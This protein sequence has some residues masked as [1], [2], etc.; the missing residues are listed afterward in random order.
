M[1]GN[2]FGGWKTRHFNLD[3]SGTLFYADANQSEILGSFSLQYAYAIPQLKKDAETDKPGFIVSEYKKAFFGSPLPEGKNN[4]GLPSG[5]I[6]V[7][8]VFYADTVQERDSW[9][10]CLLGV[11]CR[12]RP[13]DYIAQELFEKTTSSDKYTSISQDS[14]PSSRN[15]SVTNLA[16]PVSD[17]ITATKE[18]EQLQSSGSLQRLKTTSSEKLKPQESLGRPAGILASGPPSLPSEESGSN[19]PESDSSVTPNVSAPVQLP[20]EPLAA[21]ARES[22]TKMGAQR[23]RPVGMMS[24]A[25]LATFTQVNRPQSRNIDDQTRCLQQTLP[26]TLVE[27]LDLSPTKPSLDSKKKPAN[28]GKGMFKDWIKRGNSESQKPNGKPALAKP[29]FGTTIQEAVAMSAIKEGVPIPAIVY[30]CIEYLDSTKAA[31]EEGLYRLSGAS[32][33][34]SALKARFEEEGDVP[35][36]DTDQY[37]DPHAIAGLL[38]LFFRE[39]SEPLFTFQLRMNFFQQKITEVSKLIAS[40]PLPNYACL[41]A[42]LAHLLRVVQKSDVNKMTVRNI[43]IVFSPTLGVPAGLFTLF[44]AEFST[45]FAW[46]VTDKTRQSHGAGSSAVPILMSVTPETVEENKPPTREE[47]PPAVVTPQTAQSTIP[48]TADSS[49]NHSSGSLGHGQ[50]EPEPMAISATAASSTRNSSTAP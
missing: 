6:D 28:S 5:K 43:S 19:P 7:R 29:L 20:K 1:P 41:R 2:Y 44:L 21:E 23:S 10:R 14:A 45:V 16:V 50:S 17:R 26:P 36:I 48:S 13:A 3:P 25:A 8:H 37:Y 12:L 39:L 32:S 31:E 27:E 11:I 34:I 33:V 30:R 18:W 24:P 40:L 46:G 38:K 15:S 35:L 9:V 42:L 49:R 47:P 22:P 4:D